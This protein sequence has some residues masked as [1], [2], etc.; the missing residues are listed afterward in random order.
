MNFSGIISSLAGEFWDLNH[1]KDSTKVM[2][3][4]YILHSNKTPRNIEFDRFSEMY[5]MISQVLSG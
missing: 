2:I 1:E 5:E 3:E 4:R